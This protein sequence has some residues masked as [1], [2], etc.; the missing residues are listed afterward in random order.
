MKKIRK[1]MVFRRWHGRGTYRVEGVIG[2]EVYVRLLSDP[3]GPAECW[4]KER[5]DFVKGRKNHGLWRYNFS[6]HRVPQTIFVKP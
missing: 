1:G 5:F 4:Q 2:N 6:D 3:F